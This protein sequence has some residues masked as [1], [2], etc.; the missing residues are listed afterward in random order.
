LGSAK[1]HLEA[2]ISVNAL[3]LAFVKLS[4]LFYFA[5]S[6][7]CQLFSVT[8]GCILWGSLVLRRPLDL[9]KAIGILIDY[10]F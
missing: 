7:I 5:V 9:N 3:L 4:L 1:Q 10:L 2:I 6:A 8:I